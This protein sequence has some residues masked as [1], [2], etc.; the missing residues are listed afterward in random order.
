MSEDRVYDLP[1]DQESIAT[2]ADSIDGEGQR[3]TIL[4]FR[5]S[6]GGVPR[7]LEVKKPLVTKHYSLGNSRV[8]QMM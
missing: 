8:K 6:F 3:F 4:V 1:D 7:L 5:F 2:V